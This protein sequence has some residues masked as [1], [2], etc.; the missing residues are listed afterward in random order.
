MVQEIITYIIVFSAASY[1][2]FHFVKLFLPSKNGHKKHSCST[3]CSG[4]SLQHNAKFSE[5]AK[6]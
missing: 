6:F 4:C 5:L 3:G 2:F 1:S